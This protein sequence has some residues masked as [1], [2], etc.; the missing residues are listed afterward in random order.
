M[1]VNRKKH[2]K[3]RPERHPVGQS[4]TLVGQSRTLADD[5]SLLNNNISTTTMR[6]SNLKNHH[7]SSTSKLPT[8]ASPIGVPH[9][10]L[11]QY[12]H[13]QDSDIAWLEAS[14]PQPSTST[15]L[16]EQFLSLQRHGAYITDADEPVRTMASLQRYMA[17]LF[18]TVDF[19]F[20]HYYRL[21]L[22][23]IQHTPIERLNLRSLLGTLTNL[24]AANTI[25]MMGGK[26]VH[27]RNPRRRRA[28]QSS[29][30][31]RAVLSKWALNETS[32][33]MALIMSSGSLETLAIGAF[34]Q[35]SNNHAPQ[36]TSPFNE[37]L[38][39][40]LKGNANL[41][42]LV[43]H[44]TFRYHPN[45]H[46]PIGL[47]SLLRG[48][49]TLHG[50]CQLL[51]LELT[52]G[53][54][55]STVA[56]TKPPVPSDQEPL[57][58]SFGP[59]HG[60]AVIDNKS[61]EEEH[62]GKTTPPKKVIKAPS[63]ISL[64]KEAHWSSMVTLLLEGVVRC[65]TLRV[66]TIDACNDVKCASIVLPALAKVLAH[67]Q[68][69]QTLRLPGCTF[70]PTKKPRNRTRNRRTKPNNATKVFFNAIVECT[71]GLSRSFTE[72]DISGATLGSGGTVLL[73]KS[74]VHLTKV[75]VEGVHC[76]GGLR[77]LLQCFAE[78]GN[79]NAQQLCLAQRKGPTNAVGTTTDVLH[80]G[81]TS[82]QRK[83][84]RTAQQS[85]VNKKTKQHRVDEIIL[86]R[87]IEA[88]KIRAKTLVSL[89]LR[90]MALGQ[91]GG[92]S[93]ASALRTCH[94]ITALDLCGNN[95]GNV[96]CNSIFQ[97]VLPA[98][99]STLVTLKMNENKMGDN[100]SHA[101][102]KLMGTAHSLAV[103]CLSMN[104]LS[105]DTAS[106]IWSVLGRGGCAKM[107]DLD[108]SEN[109]ID[110]CLCLLEAYR[111]A[112]LRGTNTMSLKSL[113]LRGNLLTEHGTKMLSA[114]LQLT[115]KE[116]QRNRAPG[117][118]TRSTDGMLGDHSSQ[119][120]FHTGPISSPKPLICLDLSFNRLGAQG[121]IHLGRGLSNSMHLIHLSVVGCRLGSVGCDGLATG[122]LA[123]TVLETLDLSNN[124][125][126][127]DTRDKDGTYGLD[128]RG[129][130]TLSEVVQTTKTLCSLRLQHNELGQSCEFLKHAVMSN[131]SL[132][133]LDV[134][135]NEGIA[136]ETLK[137]IQR[138]TE[139]NA[140]YVFSQSLKVVQTPI[141]IRK[142]PTSP[143]VPA[144]DLSSYL[145]PSD[146]EKYKTMVSPPQPTLDSYVPQEDEH[147]DFGSLVGAAVAVQL[148]AKFQHNQQEQREDLDFEDGML[149]EILLGVSDSPVRSGVAMNRIPSLQSAHKIVLGGGGGGGGFGAEERI[150]K[151]ALRRAVERMKALM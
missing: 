10:Q 37:H 11:Y 31:A 112:G 117:L 44:S 80:L 86:L 82:V 78:R 56:Q 28:Q 132:V 62:S 70:P 121:G 55:V 17:V 13:E 24:E 94:K 18:R 151:T 20:V 63:N 123:N 128:L 72:L 109:K 77:H 88:T 92:V 87:T 85:Q 120:L 67:S 147:Y 66:V 136:S 90:N 36:P 39:S 3:G 105:T 142:A 73:C 75:V 140:R 21:Y 118:Q 139:E 49:D 143:T 137:V 27:L 93:L 19:S 103:L 108:L 127:L 83:R 114:I 100:A 43:I 124:L 96:A 111:A 107:I 29:T 6:L 50:G 98:C 60:Y 51:R 42:T 79:L 71:S 41:Q 30:D 32:L 26:E 141:P 116:D 69:L 102:G 135:Q 38:G 76:K 110:S 146:K 52:A 129:I 14:S 115:Y 119:M 65:K 130:R 15:R 131:R 2:I 134:S 57:Y 122:L 25:H 101:L 138:C 45:T 133:V 61:D 16:T 97:A 145:S 46:R 95:F 74:I 104:L 59:H 35:R 33:L 40:I 4:R 126:C 9:G 23:S 125:I 48:M 22:C 47:Q 58:S 148:E 5:S 64:V 149:A 54:F 113:S 68:S 12:L 81:E 144:R 89:H 53:C 7:R 8:F 91:K 34:D 99:G 150:D 84:N 1:N 106:V